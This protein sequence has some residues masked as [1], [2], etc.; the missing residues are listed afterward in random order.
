MLDTT[1]LVLVGTGKLPARLSRRLDEL[2]ARQH[3]PASERT[4]DVL[5][6]A[7]RDAGLRLDADATR[8]VAGHLGGDAGRVDALV[9][10]L[11]A[12]H[13]SGAALGV[14]DVRPYLGEQGSVPSY[15]LTNAIEKGD[16]P[17]AL[18]VLH[19]LLTNP[20]QAGRPMHPLQVLGMLHGQY[21]RLL[22]LDDTAVRSPADAVAALGGRV[23]EY[24]A[25]KAL[26]RS[27][28]L[29]TAGIRR[30]FDYLAQADLDLKGARGIPEDAVMDVLV[31][32]LAGLAGSGRRGRAR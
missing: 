2:G 17:G 21:R 10:V 13:G 14:D 4:S 1:E 19:R 20:G 30:A 9:D 22:R 8:L 7:L 15:E 18:E 29:G 6:D 12:A 11:V 31:A 23:K 5:A 28:A 3:A 26:D 32:R 25:R 16:V 24:P 27:R